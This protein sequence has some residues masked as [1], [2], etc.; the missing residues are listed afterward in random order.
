MPTTQRVSK[1]WNNRYPATTSRSISP[2]GRKAAMCSTY[3]PPS[4]SPP[5]DWLW[6]DN[7]SML[8]RA[9]FVSIIPPVVPHSSPTHLRYNSDT[10]PTVVR[11]Q[12]E[13]R[14]VNHVVNSVFIPSCWKPYFCCFC[15]D[16]D[17]FQA[18]PPRVH[19]VITKI[20]QIYRVRL[21]TE[22]T[23]LITEALRKRRERTE[24]ELNVNYRKLTVNYR[25]FIFGN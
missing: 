7:R 3:A 12:S 4:A 5:N 1:W 2:P 22:A 14:R 10:T 25:E 6:R 15:S 9:R 21:I 11:L 16:S 13:K 17:P 18:S 24:M 19:N 20:L 8:Y 23:F